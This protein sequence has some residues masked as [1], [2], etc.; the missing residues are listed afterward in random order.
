MR[1]DEHLHSND[2]RYG[3]CVWRLDCWLEASRHQEGPAAGQLGR[4]PWFSSV[5]E[6]M[7]RRCPEYTLY[8]VL[9]MQPSL[10]FNFRI[11]AQ[12]QPSQHYKIFVTVLTFKHKIQSKCSFCPLCCIIFQQS[13]SQRS[14]LPPSRLLPTKTSGHNLRASRAVHFLT[15]PPAS[16]WS[17]LRL[18][19]CW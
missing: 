11:F 19:H 14:I 7:L 4:F 12:T 10:I 8:C 2:C 1:R 18:N 6:Q 5:L 3:S 17:I 16:F 9:L 13:T 15:T